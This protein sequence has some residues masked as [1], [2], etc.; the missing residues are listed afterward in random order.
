[1]VISQTISQDI[2][3][4]SIEPPPC[5]PYKYYIQTGVAQEGSLPVMVGVFRGK[6][7]QSVQ[8]GQYGGHTRLRH[9]SGACINA[10]GWKLDCIG[11]EGG[12]LPES[13][14]VQRGFIGIR[15]GSPRGFKPEAPPL[16]KSP[17][18]VSQS[19]ATVGGVAAT[20]VW[21]RY[22]QQTF[23]SA[24]VSCRPSQRVLLVARFFFLALL[25]IYTS[26]TH[27]SVTAIYFLYF[28]FYF[29]D[30]AR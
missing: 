29:L 3:K 27:T 22:P 21:F 8:K 1:M 5:S 2:L 25:F 20:A 11:S 10:G 19:S 14:Q 23:H 28:Y 30:H 15:K 17:P 26:P 6:L 13:A 12:E 7:N 18:T 9:S 24:P 16:W 4:Q